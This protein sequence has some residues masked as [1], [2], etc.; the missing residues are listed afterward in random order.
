MLQ[1]DLARALEMAESLSWQDF[2]AIGQPSPV[3]ETAKR[4]AEAKRAMFAGA[5]A[6]IYAS[7][8]GQ[9]IF[10]MLADVTLFRAGFTTRM[11]LEPV[12]AAMEQS[13]RDGQC[14]LVSQLLKLAA[15]G[16]ARDPRPVSEPPEPAKTAKKRKG[17]KS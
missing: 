2:E 10:K 12:A 1:P 14:A 6:R 9:L 17:K 4:A 11:G 13:Y 3:T 15:E 8:D 5:A 16:G 7:P